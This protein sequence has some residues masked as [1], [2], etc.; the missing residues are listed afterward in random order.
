MPAAAAGIGDDAG[1][2]D[3]EDG[4]G[5]GPSEAVQEAADGLEEPLS[6]SLFPGDQACSELAM[7]RADETDQ[8]RGQALVAAAG[9]VNPLTAFAIGARAGGDVRVVM[10]FETEEQARTNAD[11]RATLASGDAPGQGG[12]FAERFDL[13][14]VSAEGDAVTM[15]LE[16]V[17]GAYV[18]SDLTTGPLLF[19]TC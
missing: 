14:R 1:G 11:T 7:G 2:D 3:E 9:P 12:T 8:Q 17:D 5:A 19:A 16:P 13:G 15:E 10:T 18:L 4:D 6:A